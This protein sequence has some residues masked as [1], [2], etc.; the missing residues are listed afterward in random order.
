MG[1]RKVGALEK[2][3]ADLPALQNKIRRDPLYVFNR[4]VVSLI[5]ADL[6]NNVHSSYKADFERQYEQ[7]K[8][9]Y[10]IFLQNA[11]TDDNSIVSLREYITFVSHVADCYPSLTAQFPDDLISL[12][13]KHHTRLEPDLRE[14]IVGALVIL[15]NKDVINSIKYVLVLNIREGS[16][17]ANGIVLAD[18]SMHYFP[19]SSRH[20]ANRC[21]RSCSKRYC[22]ICDRQMLKRQIIV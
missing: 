8:T 6:T 7:Y 12:L 18:F 22:P 14:K 5:G 16:C 2:L 1:K 13:S 10:L 17:F 19:F 21:A 9:L 3:E 4:G 20:R 15:R 11:S